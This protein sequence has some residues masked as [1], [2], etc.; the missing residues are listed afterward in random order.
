MKT[1]LMERHRDFDMQQALPWNEEALVQDLGLTAVFDAMAGG[2]AFIWD[3][4]KKAVLA[5]LRDPEAI[6]YRQHILKDCLQNR[7]IVREIY[8]I[9][10]DAIQSEKKIYFG[11]FSKYPDAILRRSIDVL[12]LLVDALKKL[13]MIAYEYAGQFKSEGF[14]TLF[15]MLREELSDEYFARVQNHLKELK[16]REG[17]LISAELG[18]GNKG[19]GYVLR[20]PNNPKH[21]GMKWILS[22]KPPVY[23]FYISDRDES[24]TKALSELK[25]RGINLVANALAQSTDHILGFFTMLRTEMAFY[26]GCL[27]LHEKLLQKGEPT[28]FPVPKNAGERRHSFKGLYDVSLSLTLPQRTVGNEVHA[29]HKDLVFITGAN[30]GGKSTFL[31]SIGLAQLMM[32]CGMFVPAESFEANVCADLFTHYKR[33][34]DATMESGKLDEELHRMS[35]IV[36]H[37]TPNS[38][39]L[40]NESFAATNEREGSEIARQVVSALLEKNIKIFYVTH[41]YELAHGFYE[42]KMGNALFLRAQRQADG[43]RTYKIIEGEPLQTSFG[44]DLYLRVF[45]PDEFSHKDDEVPQTGE[46]DSAAIGTHRVSR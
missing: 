29:D 8:Q 13:K 32:Q 34:E 7:D 11:L 21:A 35:D 5:G 14:T 17:V 2:D 45:H 22:K 28:C 44:Q 9:A 42:R 16:F 20:K 18:K 37:I 46:K 39:V 4:A 25:D 19:A 1:F 40:F 36:D 33:E 43:E 6:R 31:R 10:V 24:G 27:N 41:F 3:V 23:T 15:S 38:L 30:Q 12:Q 26:M